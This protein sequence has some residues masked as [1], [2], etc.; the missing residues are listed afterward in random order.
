MVC[1]FDKNGLRTYKANDCNVIGSIFTNDER[2][3][4]SR[5]YPLSLHR[6]KTDQVDAIEAKTEFYMA[7]TP[8][9]ETS[10]CQ[11]NFPVSIAPTIN[12]PLRVPDC[13]QLPAAL[14]AHTYI[15][16]GLSDIDRLHAKCGDVGIKY[17]KRAFPDLKIPK[18]Y[19]CEFC[20]EGK[21][22]KFGHSACAPGRRTLYEPGVCLDADHSGPYA[23]SIGGAKYSELI[24]DRGSEYFLAFRMKKTTGH[25][26]ALPLVLTDS[27]ALSGRPVQYFHSDG[28]GVFTSKETQEILLG[29]K[30][31]HEFSA[32]FDSNTNPFVERAR[33][34]VFE[35]V[36]RSFFGRMHLRV[37]G[38]GRV[39]Q[40]F[41]DQCAPDFT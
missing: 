30:V 5:L 1:V 32:P 34:T 2:D 17:M 20:I 16:S 36:C 23:S 14:L 15:K 39:S 4:K 12:M 25:Y 19:R 31:R 21:I 33:R 11:R 3:K 26:I 22:H 18:H 40:N 41:H 9:K 8:D 6:K 28:E 37:S 35:G 24:M 38:A 10:M 27:Q 29:A 13:D 7:I